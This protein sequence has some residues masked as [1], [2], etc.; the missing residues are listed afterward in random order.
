MILEVDDDNADKI[1]SRNL[2]Q[3]YIWLKAD[4]KRA[5]KNPKLFHEDD[6][7]SWE[8]LVPALEEVGKYFTYDWESEVKKAKKKL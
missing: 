2:I 4:L 3:S 8:T 5:K 6:I 1:T 7:K